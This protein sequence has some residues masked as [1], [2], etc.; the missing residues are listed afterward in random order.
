MGFIIVILFVAVIGGVAFMVM[1]TL[2]KLNEADAEQG[3]MAANSAVVDT[4]QKFL[5]F[6]NIRD[7]VIDLGNYKYRM[8]IECSS[9]N[10]ALKTDEEQEIIELGFQRVLNSLQFPFTLYVQTREI[11]N[12][13]MISSLEDDILRA[14]E[15][16]PILSDYGDSY[17]NEMRNLTANLGQT[18]QKKKYII[19]PFDEAIELTTMDKEER[20]NY[21]KDEIFQRAQLIKDGMSSL[22]IKASILNT[23]EIIELL[24]SA[25][26]KDGS[27]DVENI[28]NG[29]Y[30]RM[31]VEGVFE[32]KSNGNLL[33]GNRM[34]HMDPFDKMWLIFSQA[35]KWIKAEVLSTL[36]DIEFQALAD[37]SLQ[38]LDELKRSTENAYFDIMNDRN[39]EQKSEESDEFENDKSEKEEIGGDE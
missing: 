12:R 18:K 21:A 10:Y 17:L 32:D 37:A 38:K 3:G 28:Q 25:F 20:F 24:Y 35:E 23:D 30:L 13:A 19:V 4:A 36:S 26:H 39:G 33:I 8:I 1:R 27:T 15:D 11:D 9:I 31:M 7:G 14:K 5:P 34:A 6:D 2:N 29:E 16:F 22:Q